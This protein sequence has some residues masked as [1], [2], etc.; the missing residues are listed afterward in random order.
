MIQLL[1][2]V[3][4]LAFI[5][6]GLPDCMLGAAWPSMYGEFGVPLSYAG[7]ISLIIAFG[8]IISSL[9][10]DFLTKKLGVARVTACSVA[11]TAVAL[12]GFSVSGSYL[13]LC[14]L[15]IPYG[16]GAGSI[17][18]ALNNYVAIHYSS[19]SMS[20]LH[21]MWGLGTI[22]GPY[23]MGAALTGG[24]TWN[25]G[26]RIIS[27]IQVGI[28]I[29]V[30]LSF[31]LW[32]DR[33]KVTGSTAT[34]NRGNAASSQQQADSSETEVKEKIN[35]FT[36]WKIPG[37]L[38]MVGIFF[39]Y[40]ALEATAMLWGAT[41]LNLHCGITAEKA[42]FFASMFCI[43]ITAGRAINGFL[44]VKFDD[45]QLVRLGEGIILVGI[46]LML[47][48]RNTV[49]ALTGLVF[50]GLGCAPI[51]PSS[52][53]LTPILFG[54]ERS[55]AIIGIQMACA[56]VGIL[57]MPPVFGLIAEHIQAGL[58]PAFLLVLLVLM[59]FMHLRLVKKTIR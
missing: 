44:T 9:F 36:V 31:P 2:A 42:A 52:I 37:V 47:F 22:I 32:K 28:T 16:L 50:V 29:I 20:W 15:A 24:M 13:Q 5:S 18:A 25:T 1:L 4:Y 55:Q 17:D 26:Y 10:S 53:H 30:V 7:G 58:L 43:G 49:M 38:E 41:Y 3:I 39:T 19:R 57:T 27:Y 46:L 11:L 33:Q 6:L 8:T 56:Y 59:A 21:C 34:E 12:F 40:C 51:Y 48:Q 54:E 14:L 23:V 35:I 45:I